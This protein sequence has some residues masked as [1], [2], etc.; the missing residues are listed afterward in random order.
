MRIMEPVLTAA[1]RVRTMVGGT[2]AWDA[3]RPIYWKTISAVAGHRGVSLTFPDGHAYRIDPRFFAWQMDQ[4]EPAVVHELTRTLT[5]SSVVYD[6]GAHV[7][8]LTVIAARRVERGLVYAFEPSRP[9]FDLLA[10]HVRINGFSNRVIVS[11]VLV[12]DRMAADVPFAHRA[13]PFTA[14][15]LAYGLDGA[16]TTLTPM[17]T[18]DQLIERGEARPPSHIKIDVEGYEAAVLRGAGDTLHRFRPLV[19]CAM[20]P[21]PLA[22]LGETGAGIV[23]FMLDHGYGAFD[24]RGQSVIDPGFEE[25]LFRPHDSCAS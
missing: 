19:I 16:E 14:N 17:I 3:V 15:S 10:R 23:R 4:Y 24:L 21:E 7:G 9:N 12:G 5:D 6:V 8:I 25:I 13:E 11:N 2:R 22:L 18:I 1:R 20:H